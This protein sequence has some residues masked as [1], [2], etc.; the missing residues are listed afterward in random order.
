VWLEDVVDETAA[1]TRGQV[2][3]ILIGVIIAKV[4]TM[5]A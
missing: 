4:V 3:E 5:M 1:L 2:D